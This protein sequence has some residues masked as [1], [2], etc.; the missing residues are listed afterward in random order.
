M[1]A[2]VSTSSRGKDG[3]VRHREEPRPSTAVAARTYFSKAGFSQAE[4]YCCEHPFFHQISTTQR[5][6]GN[7]EQWISPALWAICP[8]HLCFFSPLH[9][10]PDPSCCGHSCSPHGSCSSEHS[11]SPVSSLSHFFAALDMP[12]G[13][14]KRICACV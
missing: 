7:Q 9:G 1:H 3:F 10:K 8:S 4:N 14:K 6:A 13:V 11:S 5:R 12:A 2:Y